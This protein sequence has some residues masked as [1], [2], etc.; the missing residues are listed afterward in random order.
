VKRVLWIT[1][2]DNPHANDARAQHAS[3][4]C[5]LDLYHNEN[6]RLEIFGLSREETPFNYEPFYKDLIVS[7][8]TAEEGMEAFSCKTL[9]DLTLAFRKRKFPKRS[10][11]RLK[12]Q[13]GNDFFFGVKVYA[14]VVETRRPYFSKASA[15]DLQAID[16]KTQWVNARTGKEVEKT[17]M[18]Y[19]LP[20]GGAKVE[21]TRSEV[22]EMKIKM[23]PGIFLLGFKPRSWLKDYY[24]VSHSYFIYPDESSMTGSITAFT[25]LLESMLKKN[26]I[27]ICRTQFRANSGP[28]L[29]ALL[30]QVSSLGE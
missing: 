30:P 19:Y 17:E 29:S 8:E 13:I 22:D 15:R 18:K 4:Q 24:N 20:Y 5:G 21:F 7:D 6:I 9:G 26:V 11:A 27:A 10:W 1:N 25:A 12:F 23:Q 3:K 2:V 14:T 16:T 28:R